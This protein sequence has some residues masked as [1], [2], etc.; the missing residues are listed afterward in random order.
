MDTPE[1]VIYEKAIDTWG[2][3]AQLCVV[4][5]ELAELIV[6]ISKSER[7]GAGDAQLENVCKEIADVDI[8][9]GQLRF[10]L[11]DRL[12]DSEEII[13]AEKKRKLERLERMLEGN[14]Q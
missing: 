11:N 14:G 2:V 1:N 8:V 10:I 5:E 6:A 13:A 12:I 3:P 4:K 9:L 7:D